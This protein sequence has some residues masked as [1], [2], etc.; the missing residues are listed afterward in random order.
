[1]K[2]IYISSVWYHRS[3]SL[4]STVVEITLPDLYWIFLGFLCAAG[5]TPKIQNHH[6]ARHLSSKTLHGET[7]KNLLSCLRSADLD[8]IVRAASKPR[9]E[10]WA[11]IHN[12]MGRELSLVF[13]HADHTEEAVTV[14]EKFWKR[15]VG[16]VKGG[17]NTLV[18]AA[19]RLM[20]SQIPDEGAALWPEVILCEV[21]TSPHHVF[22][23]CRGHPCIAWSLP[24]C[25]ISSR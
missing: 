6:S 4:N 19:I 10:G 17:L 25:S 1:M 7:L 13:V 15:Y 23:P 9:E 21:L 12:V 16:G 18:E 8:K 14:L 24:L 5:K 20:V 11:F 3:I 2:S 22:L